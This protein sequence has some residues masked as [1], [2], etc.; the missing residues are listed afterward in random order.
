MYCFLKDTVN[1]LIWEIVCLS[2]GEIKPST[3][4]DMKNV[5]SVIMSFTQQQ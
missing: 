3:K 4:K 5:V 1:E 2:N